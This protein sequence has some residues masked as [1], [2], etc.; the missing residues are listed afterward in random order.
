MNGWLKDKEHLARM[1]GLF[2]L[3]IVAFLLFR[4]V[5]VPAGFGRYGHYRAGAL[6]DI[7]ARPLKYAGRTACEDCHADIVAARQGSRH[8]K[9]GCE[10]CHGPSL[11]HVES[12]GGDPKPIKPDSRVLCARCHE[13]SPWKP[14]SFPQVV[15]ATHNPDAACIACHQPHA[16]KIS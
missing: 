5:M 1:A 16:P 10:A 6:D 9:I 2:L 12:G 7:R 13:A 3:G 15:V 14:K 4:A 11:K 8:A